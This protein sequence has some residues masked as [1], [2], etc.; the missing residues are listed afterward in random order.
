MPEPKARLKYQVQ[1]AT[2][3]DAHFWEIVKLYHVRSSIS[4]SE[5][6]CKL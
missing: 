6:P 1:K 2:G 5:E 4:A 3:Y